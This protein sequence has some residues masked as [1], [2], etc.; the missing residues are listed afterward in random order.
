MYNM[1]SP[2]E[3]HPLR[4]PRLLALYVPLTV[5]YPDCAGLLANSLSPHMSSMHSLVHTGLCDHIILSAIQDEPKI[6]IGAE[7]AAHPVR[8]AWTTILVMNPNDP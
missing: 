5:S 4:L 2:P 3:P 8:R 1:F 7:T 6:N